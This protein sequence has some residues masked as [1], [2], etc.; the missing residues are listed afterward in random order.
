MRIIIVPDHYRKGTLYSWYF[1]RLTSDLNFKVLY[2]SEYEFDSRMKT[3][4]AFGV[5]HF[6]WEDTPEFIEGLVNLPRSV[7][8]ISWT[9]DLHCGD[10]GGTTSKFCKVNTIKIFQ[11]AN[12]IVSSHDTRMKS[13][14]KKYEHKYFYLP[15]TFVPQDVYLNFKYNTNPKLQC[16]MVGTTGKSVYP[17]RYKIRNYAKKNYSITYVRRVPP[18]EYPGLLHQYLCGL[19]DIGHNEV[20]QP[21][22][23][24][25]PAVGSLL[26]G[27]QTNLIDNLG[28]IPYE[29]YIPF[30]G[31]DVFEIS[32]DI[33]SEPSKYEGIRRKGMEFARRH[34]L[35]KRMEELFRVLYKY[36]VL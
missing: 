19:V 11:R 35:D 14:Y 1:N 28:F 10:L 33:V 21:K 32:K 13:E 34:T 20:V 26:L 36:E 31:D 17:L 9:A 22:Y 4:I 5:P 15:W 2:T 27:R 24:E 29:H 18:K 23:F 25:I 12:L 8:L 30:T 16:L 7:K 3:I 6:N